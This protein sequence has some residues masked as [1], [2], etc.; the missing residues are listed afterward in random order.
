MQTT[1]VVLSQVFKLGFQVC[2]HY[3][4]ENANSHISGIP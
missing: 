4:E 1:V 3:K 2:R